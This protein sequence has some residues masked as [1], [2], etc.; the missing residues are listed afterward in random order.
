[1]NRAGRYEHTVFI[2]FNAVTETGEPIGDVVAFV[3]WRECIKDELGTSSEWYTCSCASRACYIE[4]ENTSVLGADT[5][6]LGDIGDCQG[7]IFAF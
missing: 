4:C 6:I 5:L 7:R 1:M 2:G 3:A